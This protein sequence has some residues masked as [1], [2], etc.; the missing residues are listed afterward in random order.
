MKKINR[1][2]KAV[3]NLSYRKFQLKIVNER[4]LHARAS[5]KFAAMVD[6]F[7]SKVEVS[8]EGLTVPGNSIMGLLTLAAEKGVTLSLEIKGKDAN[9]AAESLTELVYNFFG[10]GR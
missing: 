3:D 9:E 4:G 5:A 8:R 2:G 10:E 6:C 1:G 7:E